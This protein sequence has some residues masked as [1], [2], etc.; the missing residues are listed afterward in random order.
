MKEI[1]LVDLM[2]LRSAMIVFL[3]F[4]FKMIIKFQYQYLSCLLHLLYC[5]LINWVFTVILSFK[6]IWN[7]QKKLGEAVFQMGQNLQVAAQQQVR[8]ECSSHSSQNSML[9]AQRRRVSTI[10]CC[11][12]YWHRLRLRDLGMDL[13][14]LLKTWRIWKRN[15]RKKSKTWFIKGPIFK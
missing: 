12:T 10:Y 5:S 13:K 9:S 7:Q 3:D 1:K 4:S 11:W 2:L 8:K 14:S 6:D 15:W